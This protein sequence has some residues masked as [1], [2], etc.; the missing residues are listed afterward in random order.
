MESNDFYLYLNNNNSIKKYI[1]N[2]V[3][4]FT[5]DI[6][7]PIVFSEPNI[8][9]V[10]LTSCIVP[11]EEYRSGEI[12]GNDTFDVTWRIEMLKGN[13][14]KI[15]QFTAAVNIHLILGKTPTE[16]LKII[17]KKCVLTS[18]L[19]ESFFNRFLNIY[20]DKITI[21]RYQ[22]TE[23]DARGDNPLSMLKSVI[24][25]INP[26]MQKL[27]GLNKQKYDLFLI[28]NNKP[29]KSFNTILGDHKIGFALIPSKY[30]IIYTDI[31]NKNRFGDRN[32]SILDI[33]PFGNSKLTERK[34]N[35][36]VYTTVKPN[37]IYDISI[38]IHDS[39]H[40]KLQNHA[41]DVVL[42]L[43]FRK[44]TDSYLAR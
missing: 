41:E 19:P 34:L 31:I 17:I 32:L 5:N 25:Y 38:M 16:I 15:S 3:S 24:L 39:T 43:H 44:K 20:G 22:F 21:T 6:I 18:E 33:L 11:F 27:F 12:L 35:E 37:I 23:V 2:D 26:K 29:L 4:E 42:C 28:D 13:E 8:W 10:A 36:R 9:E 7:P 1:T 14:I 40:G 30:I